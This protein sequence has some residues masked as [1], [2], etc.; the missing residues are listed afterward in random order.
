M[1]T[2]LAR[3]RILDQISGE[4]LR[5]DELWGTQDH[6]DGK[7]MIILM[8]EIGEAAKDIYENKQENADI[9]LVQCAAVIVAWLESRYRQRLAGNSGTTHWVGCHK[10]HEGCKAH[11]P[12]GIH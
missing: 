5:Q 12:K 10:V 2:P 6:N 1:S 3:L 11:E 8:E 9:E 4:R 7:W